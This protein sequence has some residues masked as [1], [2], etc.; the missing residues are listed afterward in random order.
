MFFFFASSPQRCDVL[1]DYTGVL[2]KRLSTMCWS[3][4]HATVKAVKEK[5]DEYVS[6]IEVL[7]DPDLDTRVTARIPAVCNFS[8]LC[9]LYF[10]CDVLEEVNLTW[11]YLQSKGLTLDKVVTKLEILRFFSVRAAQSSSRA[12]N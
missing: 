7:C 10:R 11:L 12:G 3:F 2:V 5:F 4:H 6:A 8:F 9:C 1:M